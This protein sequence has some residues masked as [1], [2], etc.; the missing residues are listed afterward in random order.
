MSPVFAMFSRICK[1]SSCAEITT[2]PVF[3]AQ[4]AGGA[5]PPPTHLPPAPL[6]CVEMRQHL[7]VDFF[8]I[9]GRVDGPNEPADQI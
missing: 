4:G 2:P 6:L 9:E 8:A 7:R 1:T 5:G 3:V